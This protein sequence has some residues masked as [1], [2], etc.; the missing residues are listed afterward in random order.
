MKKNIK[1]LFNNYIFQHEIVENNKLSN[2][3]KLFKIK[4]IT[5]KLQFFDLWNFCKEDNKDIDEIKILILFL[6]YVSFSSIPSIKPNLKEKENYFFN[7]S[8]LDKLN[9]NFIL[10]NLLKKTQLND[11]IKSKQIDNIN[12]YKFNIPIKS[13]F[14]IYTFF[15]DII[16]DISIEDL[17][18][19]CTIKFKEIK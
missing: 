13:F 2:L 1:S 12:F 5:Y 11:V 7:L 10:F 17:L 8:N 3:N 4:K 18:I 14:E 15:T 19:K 16:N 9:I 6:F